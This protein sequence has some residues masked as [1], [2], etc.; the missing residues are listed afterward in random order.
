LFGRQLPLLLGEQRN[1]SDR[2]EKRDG[3]CKSKR[4]FHNATP[5]GC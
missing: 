5:L 2:E 3:D 1:A 4:A